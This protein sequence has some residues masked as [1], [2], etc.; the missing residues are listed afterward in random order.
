[1]EEHLIQQGWVHDPSE[2]LIAHVGGLWNRVHNS[3]HQF[4]FLAAPMH[5]NR[6]GVVHGGMLMVFVDRAYGLTARLKSGATRSAT[7]SL[8]HQFMAPMPIGGFALIEPQVGSLTTR[9]A[10]M[11]GSVTCDNIPIVSAQGVW[12][13]IRTPA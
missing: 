12:R 9:L 5:A 4:G 1:M 8:N 10:F 7:I 2:G 3:T 13:L 6:N 11:Q